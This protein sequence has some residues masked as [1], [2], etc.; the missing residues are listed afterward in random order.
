M[1]C[2]GGKYH[3]R[4]Y[5][6][7]V[8]ERKCR[9][10]AW[11][12]SRNVSHSGVSVVRNAARAPVRSVG[13]SGMGMC[14]MRLHASA[15]QAAICG[16]SAGPCRGGRGGRAEAQAAG[17]ERRGWFS[18]NRIA[19]GRKP[20]AVERG[21]EPGS[22][23]GAFGREVD[24]DEV[25]VGAARDQAETV[26]HERVGEAAGIRDDMRGIAAERRTGRFP[27][28]RRCRRRR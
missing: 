26:A 12:S 27:A 8:G 10:S 21:F 17:P 4:P 9:Q 15:I 28:R 5:G 23:P 2:M 18:G 24:E 3:G 20:D 13:A 7:E 1:V 22:A 11:T 14:R 6:V 16:I 25:G 19:V